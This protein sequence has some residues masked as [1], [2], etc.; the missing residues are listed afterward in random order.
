M[1]P[2]CDMTLV[3]IYA[4]F[5]PEEETFMQKEL[6]GTHLGHDLAKLWLRY[7]KDS[8]HHPLSHAEEKLDDQ[9]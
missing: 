3:L 8:A 5:W 4:I 9:I 7:R 1:I 2:V 6:E